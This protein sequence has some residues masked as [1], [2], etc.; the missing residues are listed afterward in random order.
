M[1]PGRLVF[2][3]VAGAHLQGCS[4][5]LGRNVVSVAE[6]SFNVLSLRPSEDVALSRYTENTKPG[7]ALQ[8]TRVLTLLHALGGRLR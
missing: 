2:V 3:V 5:R 1:L 6:S 7:M 4:G 8:L